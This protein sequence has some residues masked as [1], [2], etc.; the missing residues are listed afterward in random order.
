MALVSRW[1]SFDSVAIASCWWFFELPAMMVDVVDAPS[2]ILSD[3]GVVG[4]AAELFQSI[5]VRFG[6]FGCGW[7]DASHSVDTFPVW[8]RT[9]SSAHWSFLQGSLS[10]S[11]VFGSFSMRVDLGIDGAPTTLRWM[12][13]TPSRRRGGPFTGT[14]LSWLILRDEFKTK[15]GSL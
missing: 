6:A 5:R 7:C 10:M 2:S 15:F 12:M 14:E 11:P 4:L 13:L 9:W 8:R 1:S 3:N